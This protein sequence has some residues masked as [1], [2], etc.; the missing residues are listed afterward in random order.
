MQITRLSGSV[1]DAKQQTGQILLNLAALCFWDSSYS[2][3]GL[4]EY[5]SVVT[6][7]EEQSEPVQNGRILW[8]SVDVG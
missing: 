4:L 2:S 6:L 7:Q 1:L 3:V 5:K 8:K